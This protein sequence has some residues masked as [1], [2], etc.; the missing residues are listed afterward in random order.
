M[1]RMIRVHWALTWEDP[2]E[3]PPWG[4]DLGSAH[5]QHG[6]LVPAAQSLAETVSGRWRSYHSAALLISTAH[7]AGSAAGSRGALL[8]GW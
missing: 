3:H 8:H 2:T 1:H 4:L 6:T 7:V 5:S